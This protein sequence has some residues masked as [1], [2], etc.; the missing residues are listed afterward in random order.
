MKKQRNI[1]LFLV[2]FF[3]TYFILFGTYSFYLQKTQQKG[4]VFSCSP[5][6]HKV[7]QQTNSVLSL[8][9]YNA[10]VVQH[11]KE[12]SV[13]IVL[14]GY[15]IARVIEGCNSVSILIL[16]LAFVVAFPGSLKATILFSIAGSLIIYAV[17]ILRIA[18]L[19]VMLFKY[20]DHQ[21]LLHNLV[22]PA[23]IYGITF[24]LWVLWVHKFSNYKK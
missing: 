19:T 3:A 2:K 15:Y 22:F 8:F 5:I 17:N 9:G 11:N 12:M 16:F 23:I 6:T 14:N 21:T 1:V 20:H 18:F 4:D 10:S 7:A 24:L 13:K